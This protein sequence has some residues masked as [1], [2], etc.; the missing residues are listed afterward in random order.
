MNGTLYM[1]NDSLLTVYEIS[2]IKLRTFDGAVRTIECWY[3]PQIKRNLISLSTLDSQ[4]YGFYVENSIL[5]VCKCSIVFMK[6]SLEYR[7]YVLWKNIV[8]GEL[9]VTSGSNNQ[10]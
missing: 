1:G 7:L 4:L 5:E 2:D 9:V 3:V 8:L 6:A 10:N